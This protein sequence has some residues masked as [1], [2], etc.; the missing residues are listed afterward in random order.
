[1]ACFFEKGECTFKKTLVLIPSIPSKNLNLVYK[2]NNL[3]L[4]S[5]MQKR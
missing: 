4:D 3:D 2:D 1:M 5:N